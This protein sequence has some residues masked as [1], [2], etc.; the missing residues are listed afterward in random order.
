MVVLDIDSS[1]NFTGYQVKTIK[2]RFVFSRLSDEI[3]SSNSQQKA[4][5]LAQGLLI[6]YSI[7]NIFQAKK[8]VTIFLKTP[9]N[10]YF[11]LMTNFLKITR[12]EDSPCN[13]LL[14]KRRFSVIVLD[15]GYISMLQISFL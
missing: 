3:C 9:S 5:C 11:T 4:I 15:L 13:I 10:H 8:I 1:T 7:R 12:K 14:S 6:Y 2:L